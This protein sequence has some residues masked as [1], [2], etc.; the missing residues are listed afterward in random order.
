MAI[1]RTLV[2]GG[3]ATLAAF[4][5]AWWSNAEDKSQER[6]TPIPS[7]VDQ[8]SG[9]K[10]AVGPLMQAKLSHAHR[11]LEGLV[12]ND[13]DRVESAAHALKHMSLDPPEGWK[14]RDSDGEVYDHFRMEF[15]RQSAQLE[16][17]A[18]EKNLAGAAWYQ[19]NLTSTCIACHTYIRDYG[20]ED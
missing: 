16:K 1:F 13:F 3:V 2:T 14:K 20:V 6:V 15:M 19:Q 10:Q 9:S 5:G 8:E 17:M 18:K 11:V 4:A 7:S 12:T